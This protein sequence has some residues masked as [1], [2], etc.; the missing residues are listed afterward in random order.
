MGRMTPRAL[1][2]VCPMGSVEWRVYACDADDPD[3]LDRDDVRA[4]IAP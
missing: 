3:L 4:K 2:A 1:Y